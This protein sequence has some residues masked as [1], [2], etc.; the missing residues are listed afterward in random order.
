[1][2]PYMLTLIAKRYELASLL[3]GIWEKDD[4]CSPMEKKVEVRF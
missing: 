3:R 2:L 1:M 4:I